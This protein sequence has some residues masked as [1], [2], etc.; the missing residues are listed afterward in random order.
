MRIPQYVTEEE[1]KTLI[2]IGSE[3]GVL[4]EDEKQMLSGI[5]D[6]G[7]IVVREVM[8]PRVD[9]VCVDVLTPLDEIVALI[10]KN[11]IYAPFLNLKLKTHTSLCMKQ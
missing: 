6:L 10:S 9:M 11:V 5:F 3:E 8:T 1:L 2:D 4:E 7:E